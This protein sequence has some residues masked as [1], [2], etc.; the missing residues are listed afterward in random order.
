[1]SLASPSWLARTRPGWG[2]CWCAVRRA[3]TPGL[4]FNPFNVEPSLD[5]QNKELK[6]GR[7]AMWGIMSFFAAEF[8]PGS[9]PG[10]PF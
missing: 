4:V 8:V 1:M 5:A 3:G 2:G 10:Y 7:L 9:V 6:N